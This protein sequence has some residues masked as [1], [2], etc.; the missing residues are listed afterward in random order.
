M[1]GIV[2]PSVSVAM[3]LAMV[4]SFAFDDKQRA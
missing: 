4:W 2:T 3:M 1:A